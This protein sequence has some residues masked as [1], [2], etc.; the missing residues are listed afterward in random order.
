MMKKTI[1]FFQLVIL[2][3]TVSMA[4]KMPFSS[5]SGVCPTSTPVYTP[6]GTPIDVYIM[7]SPEL[8][9]FEKDS[10]AKWCLKYYPNTTFISEATRSYNC[11]AYAWYKVEGGNYSI[12]IPFNHTNPNTY[13]YTLV[14]PQ[15]WNDG[16]YVAT[17]STSAGK[18]VS[19]NAHSPFDHSAITTN[20]SGILESKWGYGPVMRHT[21]ENCPYYFSSIPTT[22]TYYQYNPLCTSPISSFINQVVINTNQTVTGCIINAQN[23]TVTNN[24]KLV[25]DGIEGV[26]INGS[27]EVQL[28]SELEVKFHDPPLPPVIKKKME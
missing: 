17:T 11:H 4:Q 16:S 24:K 26:T 21:K 20:Q 3:I 27:F 19:Y 25:F 12:Q 14:V 13:I 18:K 10:L 2:S 28:G 8:T 7:T 1:T 6:R 15:Y 5:G 22:V 23:V 9:F